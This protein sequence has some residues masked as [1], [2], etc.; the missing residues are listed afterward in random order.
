MYPWVRDAMPPTI[1]FTPRKGLGDGSLSAV[2]LVQADDPA[3]SSFTVSV[4][5]VSTVPLG[6]LGFLLHGIDP[7]SWAEGVANSRSLGTFIARD[8]THGDASNLFSSPST[9]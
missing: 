3:A 2:V 4:C 1:M 5:L 8:T 6:P 7:V 9:S